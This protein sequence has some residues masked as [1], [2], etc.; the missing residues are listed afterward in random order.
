MK[1]QREKETDLLLGGLCACGT[2]TIRGLE[3]CRGF[4]EVCLLF[5]CL[6]DK[7][8]HGYSSRF[9]RISTKILILQI[10]TS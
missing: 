3:R 5:S 7:H 4:H 9:G 2:Q 6:Q 1:I 10:P 8:G